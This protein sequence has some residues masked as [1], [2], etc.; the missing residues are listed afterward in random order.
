MDLI[1]ANANAYSWGA[2]WAFQ[3]AFFSTAFV[4]VLLALAGLSLFFRERRGGVT[5][6]LLALYLLVALPVTASVGKAGAWE[7]YFLES[8]WLLCALAGV[9]IQKLATLAPQ[10]RGASALYGLLVPFG[11]VVQVVLF[12]R[13]LERLS[14]AEELGWFESQQQAATALHQALAPV[15]SGAAVWSEHAGLLA[16]TGRANPLLPFGYTQ[17]ERQQLWDPTPLTDRLA[18]GEGA[19][20]IQRWDALADPLGLERWSRSMLAAG[21]RG[22]ALGARAGE[23][24]VRPASPF[25]PPD[26]PQPLADGLLLVDWM[27][28]APQPCEDPGACPATPLSLPV[29][30]QP[31]TPLIVHL[32]WKSEAREAVPLSSSAQLFAPDGTRVAQEDTLLRRDG[33]GGAWPAGSL[34]RDEHFLS[35]PDALEPGAYSLLLTLYETESGNPRGTLAL[36]QFKVPPAPPSLTLPVWRDV[37]FGPLLLLGRDPTPPRATA[38]STL[39]LRAHWQRVEPVDPSLTTF[40]H[41]VAPD[42]SLAAQSDHLPPYPPTLWGSDEPVELSHTLPLPATL[43]PGRYELRLGWYEAT[44]LARL[45]AQ[46]PDAVESMLR[47]GAVD[48]SAP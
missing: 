24:R 5:V 26:Q 21:E 31:G 32:L 11:L 29:T 22:F 14:V 47:L 45:P 16:E 12:G 48:I 42:G 2:L 4:L 17:L 7:N 8:F 41:L 20:L 36:R 37:S 3:R 10:Q 44:T 28:L 43:A 40:L 30:L 39:Q 46:G 27:V 13:G 1:L 33:L 19:L 23:W 38:G 25:P 9:G 6:S 18:T 35:L 15:P 34:A